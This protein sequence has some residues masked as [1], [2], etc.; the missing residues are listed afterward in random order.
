MDKVHKPVIL[1]VA[2][3][4]SNLSIQISCFLELNEKYYFSNL[5]I[6]LVYNIIF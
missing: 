5:Y 1:S 3:I 4:V 2:P 6:T